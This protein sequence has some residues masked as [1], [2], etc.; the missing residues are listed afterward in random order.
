MGKYSKNFQIQFS[1]TDIKLN[2]KLYS[3]INKMQEASSLHAEILGMGYEDLMAHNLG[4]IISKY[5]IQVNSYPKWDDIIT[6]ETWPSG[7]DRLFAMRKFLIYNQDKEEIGKIY[8]NYFLVDTKTGR[9]QGTKALPVD[10][11]PMPDEENEKLRKFRI[12]KEAPISIC[13]RRVHYTDLDLNMHMNNACYVQWVEDCFSLDYHRNMEIR[14]MQVNF[15]SGAT[16]GE[17]VVI[18]VYKNTEYGDSYYIQGLEKTK[19]REIF[20]AKVDWA[21]IS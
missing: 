16:I 12:P 3:L 8:S 20:Q 17:E 4:W 18:S 15:I 10:F 6:I 1:E 11:P 7:K 14:D 19:G 5:K 9:P 2:L 21:A 13:N